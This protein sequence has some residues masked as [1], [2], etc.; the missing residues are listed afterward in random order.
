MTFP[1]KMKIRAREQNG[2]LVFSEGKDERIQKAANRLLANGAAERILVIDSP[3]TGNH[4]GYIP[5][6]PEKS[7]WKDRVDSFLR[8]SF[9]DPADAEPVLDD[10]LY[11]AAGLVAIGEADA[12]VAGATHPT[13]HVLRSALTVVGTRT[14]E[15]VVS[16][17]F[18]ME[19]QDSRFGN[20][21]SLIFS[22]PAVL[23]SPEP[24]ELADVASG[25]VR[26][27]KTLVGED[28]RVAFLSFSTRG[29]AEHEDVDRIR[30][31]VEHFTERYPD[32]SSDGEL[33]ADAA[34]VKDVARRKA[35]NSPVAG[36]ANTLIFPDLDAANIGYKLVQWLGNAGAYGPFLQGLDDVVNDLSRGCSVED[37]VTVGAVSL[38]QSVSSQE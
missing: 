18:V 15:Q 12:M 25:A 32:I 2:V 5:V 17:S 34:L 20:E 7:E 21:G 23:P 11:Q 9:E 30:E 13:A 27:F 38:V 28:P 29:S 1:K 3:V 4:K 37:V 16:S 6:D 36:K 14:G 22:D 8:N 33:Q 10:P 26:T 19:V 31:A 24:T 35:P